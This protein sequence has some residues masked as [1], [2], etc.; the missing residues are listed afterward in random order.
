MVEKE[1]KTTIHSKNQKKGKTVMLCKVKN[2]SGIKRAGLVLGSL[3]LTTSQMLVPAY[4]QTT[5]KEGV[6]N[7]QNT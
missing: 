1:P 5:L 6:S 4:A 7:S 3:L 2:I